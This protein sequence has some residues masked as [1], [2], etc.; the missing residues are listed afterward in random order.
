MRILA[1]SCRGSLSIAAIPLADNIRTQHCSCSR[2]LPCRPSSLSRSTWC[3]LR[4]R[5]IRK[6]KR[7]GGGG[8]IPDLIHPR[9]TL[10]VNACPLRGFY[11]CRPILPFQLKTTHANDKADNAVNSQHLPIVDFCWYRLSCLFIGLGSQNESRRISRI[12]GQVVCLLR[13]GVH[14]C[15]RPFRRRPQKPIVPRRRSTIG[16]RVWGRCHDV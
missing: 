16:L 3:C 15:P 13:L 5:L 14:P 9:Y 10:G 7:G 1:F 2:M 8:M 4:L 12:L 11:P 6:S